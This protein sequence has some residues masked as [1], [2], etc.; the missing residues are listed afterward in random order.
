MT[1]FS[2]PVDFTSFYEPQGALR[3]PTILKIRHKVKSKW[4]DDG[5]FYDFIVRNRSGTSAFKKENTFQIRV[6][7]VKVKMGFD[8]NNHALGLACPK[9]F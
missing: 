2:V 5:D 3:E 9:P 7:S 4:E 1:P 8:F 6:F